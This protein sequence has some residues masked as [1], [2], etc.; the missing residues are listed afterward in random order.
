MMTSSRKGVGDHKVP[1]SHDYSESSV[2]FLD[3]GRPKFFWSSVKEYTSQFWPKYVDD[4][5]IGG[6]SRKVV[7]FYF[8][9]TYLRKI[10]CYHNETNIFVYFITSLDISSFPKLKY[11]KFIPHFFTNVHFGGSNI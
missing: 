2:G 9:D 4:R 1:Q 3:A 7:K 10:L 11:G 8:F 6:E 5:D